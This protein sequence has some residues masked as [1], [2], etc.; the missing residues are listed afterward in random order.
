MRIQEIQE[1]VATAVLGG[2]TRRIHLDV[3]DQRVDI[4]DHVIVHAGFAIH[5]IS[6]EEARE[7]LNLFREAGVLSVDPDWE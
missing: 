3:L 1:G 6:K 7:T 2:T 5:K 4:G